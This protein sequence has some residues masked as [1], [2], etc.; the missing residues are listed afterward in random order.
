MARTKQARKAKESNGANLGFE[1]KLW[2]AA[3]K[4]R[5]HMD[6]AEYKHVVLGLIF[7]KY[8]SDAFQ[9][10][11][12]KLKKEPHA[13]PED[14]DEYTA[15]NVF[16]V[17][18][19]ARWL[20]PQNNAKQPTIGKLID[21]PA[22][23][24]V[25]KRVAAD[26]NR[27]YL[28]YRDVSSAALEVDPSGMVIAI[29]RQVRDFEMPGTGI[30]DFETHARAIAKAQQ[31]TPA[32]ATERGITECD[33]G[34][35]QGRSLRDLAKEPLWRTVQTQPSAAAFPDGVETRIRTIGNLVTAR[36]HSAV[37]AVDLEAVDAA[38]R[39]G[40]LPDWLM[41]ELLGFRHMSLK[42]FDDK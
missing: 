17:P 13:N 12:E 4:M 42:I 29:E 32:T 31:G 24:D 16:W 8:I 34:S 30:I 23:Y 20:H 14:R 19:A 37:L 11:H 36:E 41:R 9:E 39:R 40:D 38:L 10:H 21:D 7:L 5:G 27:H 3:D 22:G 25:M 18:K 2:Q 28:F 6:S 26:E 15:E 33:Y 35:W 1:Q